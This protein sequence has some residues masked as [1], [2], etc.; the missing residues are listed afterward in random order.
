MSYFEIGRKPDLGPGTLFLM[1]RRRLVWG[2]ALG[3]VVA[4]MAGLLT[5]MYGSPFRT[6]VPVMYVYQMDATQFEIGL[7]C[8]KRGDV[9]IVADDEEMV[10]IQARLQRSPGD[11][12]VAVV[13]ELAQPLGGRALVDAYDDRSLEVAGRER[14]RQD[15]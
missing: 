11:C 7:E 12:G 4:G 2:L 3:T 15:P 8:G 9:A 1:V 5:A 10:V 14:Q 6:S 13:I